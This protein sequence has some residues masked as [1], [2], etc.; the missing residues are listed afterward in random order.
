MARPFTP[1]P[2][3]AHSYGALER[4]LHPRTDF[5][6]Q[7][8]F[9]FLC[10]CICSHTIDR[11]TGAATAAGFR[12][13]CGCRVCRGLKDKRAGN[14]NATETSAGSAALRQP[15]KGGGGMLPAGPCSWQAT[16][17]LTRFPHLHRE[18][19]KNAQP[20]ASSLLGIGF[21]RHHGTQ[22]G[23]GQ[24]TWRLWGVC[25]SEKEKRQQTIKK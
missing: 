8:K 18:M 25:L 15:A 24:T 6:L 22:P 20:S 13:L 14:K 7:M 17:P 2:G 1:L 5:I 16:P 10:K 23:A 4:G 11:E 9:L 21:S 12:P 3:R 19:Y